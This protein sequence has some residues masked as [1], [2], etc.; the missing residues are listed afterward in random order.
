MAKFF[1]SDWFKCITCL[2]AIALVL[3]GLLAVLNDVLA[4]SDSERTAR[5]IKKIYGEDKEY[6]ITLDVDKGDKAE[7]N[8]YGLIDKI[9][10]VGNDVLFKSTGKEGYKGGT[11]TLW[12]KIVEKD[13]NK[14]ID[15]IVQ[16]SY[17][18]QTLMSK[19]SQSYYDNFL[20]D[21]TAAYESGTYIFAPKA[22][23]GKTQNAMSGATSSAN[24]ACNAVNCVIEYLTGGNA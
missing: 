2:L 5:A 12:V 19:F 17:E 21:V 7:E 16:D 9:Y 15:K 23:S 10:Q 8:Q 20:M 24:A 13:G 14:V 4:V 6:S 3:S 22:E 18:K 1:K 11:I